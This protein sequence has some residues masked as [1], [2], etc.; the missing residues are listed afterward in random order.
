MIKDINDE[1]LGD[2][3]A[4]TWVIEFQKRGLPHCHLLIILGANHKMTFVEEYDYMVS[5]E[6]SNP[7]L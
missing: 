1:I 7:T 3:I 4:K 6:L 2:V 5:A